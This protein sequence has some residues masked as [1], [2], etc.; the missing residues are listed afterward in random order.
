MTKLF[1]PMKNFFD[2]QPLFRVVFKWKI[3]LIIVG[4]AT[5][6]LASVFS[7]PTFITPLY[8][9]Q[10][11]LYPTNT[12][13][14]SEESESEQL[15]EILSSNDLKREMIEIFNLA[16]RYHV[17]PADLHFRTKILKEYD[18]HVSCK[19]TEYET[20]ELIVLD[21]DPQVASDMVDSLIVFYNRKVQALRKEKYQ[22]LAFSFQNDLTRKETEID[23]LSVKMEVL[24]RNYG[25]LDYEIQ[26]EQLTSGYA[27]VLARGANTT[28]V[29]DIR[30]R[31]DALAEKGGEYFMYQSMMT[32]LEVERD[33]ISRRLDKALSQTNKKETYTMVVEE[34]FPADKKSYPTRWLIV[35]VSLVAV[36][37]FALLVVFSINSFKKVNS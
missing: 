20:I 14:F 23:S 19:K 35:L 11:R 29:S 37:F 30:K 8:K 3:H 34:P 18:D 16:D 26:V 25:M 27:N 5:I 33:T 6:I 4:L 32:A 2:N 17:D 36:E 9:S 22:E 21:A 7:S 1:L 10:G 13:P 24:R 28:A 15:L 12:R 31:L